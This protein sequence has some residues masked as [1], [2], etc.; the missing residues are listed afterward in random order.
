VYTPTDDG[1]GRY[2]FVGGSTVGG[3][4][5]YDDGLFLYS[6]H[7]TDPCS[8]RLVN[9]FDLVR[10]HKY[11]E[12]DDEAKPDTPVNKL[13]SFVAMSAFA[14]NDAG[15]AA[16]INQERYEK[17]LEDFGT[18]ATPV[19][20]ED[21]SWIQS[22]QISPT[23]GQPLKN[24]KNLLTVLDGDPNLKGKIRLDEFSNI[25]VGEGSFPW[26]P[27]ENEKG[28]FQWVSK[29]DDGLMVYLE[30]VLGF[31]SEGKTSAALTQVASK[32]RFDPVV[33][34]LKGL[35]WD[36]V[37]RLETLFIDYLG[38]EDT[39]YVRAVTKKSFTAAVARAMD[40]GCKYD[41]MLVLVGNQGQGK[42]SILDIMAKDWFS[43]D[44]KTF[45]GKEA[46][47]LLPGNWILEVGEMSAYNRSDREVIKGFLSRRVDNYRPAYARK[48]EK[49]PRRCVFFG[50]T[51]E[52]DFL[53]DATGDRR[54]WPVDTAKQEPRK[55]IFTDLPREVDQLW[56]EAY[57]YWVLGEPLILEDE[58]L[59]EARRVQEAHKATDVWESEIR[60]FIER[61]V[62]PNWYSLSKDSRRLFWDGEFGKVE[63][64]TDWILRDRI[65]AQ[66]VWFELFRG[67]LKYFKR[68]EAVR[69]N[70]VLRSTPGWKKHSGALRYGAYGVVKGGS[71]R[72]ENT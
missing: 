5:I 18:S 56:A 67:D 9:A 32:Y 65:C 68:G 4:V 49:F 40:P 31:W 64:G 21:V 51:N 17:A 20:D 38:A 25:I 11:G 34:Y 39:K 1:S 7:A 70:D 52:H 45:D 60:E 44:L 33:E 8:G 71:V 54:F 24:S 27:R 29:D 46:A 10:L 6:H 22:L 72:I 59:E 14:L 13:P 57:T 2:T 16:I 61:P 63:P 36:G 28:I 43:D 23:T 50:T 62:P 15:V 19:K 53:N 69:I 55:H 48:A 47:E 3:A 30:Q 35:K 12:Q 58:L 26:S 42:S 41:T 66:E 37:S